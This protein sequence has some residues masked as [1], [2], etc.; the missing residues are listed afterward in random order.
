MKILIVK[1][2]SL[3]DIIQTLPVLAFLKK[4]FPKSEI[5]W[6]A[7]KPFC[8]I[9]DAHP[10]LS[11]VIPVEIRTWKKHLLKSCPAMRLAIQSLRRKKYDLLFDLQGNIK[12]ALITCM[13]RAREKIGTT[14][15]SAPEWPNAL[16]LTKRYPMNKED[17]I[18]L[19]Y[20]SIPQRHFG[21]KPHPVLKPLSLPI[22]PE[23]TA[24]V[25]ST[26]K[27]K[28]R[29]MVCLGSHWENKKLSLPT[30]I[31]LLKKEK[32]AHLYLVWGNEREK[33]EA[34]SL[35]AQFPDRSTLLPRM[36]LPLWQHFMS[37]MDAIFTVDSSAL[38]LAATTSVP[39]Y[40]FFGPSKAS[41]YK[42]PLPHHRAFQAPCPYGKTF[43]K[44]CPALRTCKTGAC[45][46][47]LQ[48][49]NIPKK[50]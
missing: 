33:Q 25:A 34:L 32:E 30:W 13:A 23:E 18:S 46:K 28:R 11:S 17:P 24:W 10:H 6:V 43:T 26:L 40:S 15:A 22:T 8:E 37:H 9:L 39:T 4:R 35:Q 41:I 38:H 5:D 44:R 31:E 1:T 49:I 2:S 27:K 50:G 42:P 14:F 36:R 16:F 21:L 20:L 12:S 29:M 7:E 19:Q 48:S 45:L 3:G 47:S